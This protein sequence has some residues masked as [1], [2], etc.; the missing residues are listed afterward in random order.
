MVFRMIL[1]LR[2]AMSRVGEL[3]CRL[4]TKTPSKWGVRVKFCDDDMCAK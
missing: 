1:L 4:D 2:E 3:R